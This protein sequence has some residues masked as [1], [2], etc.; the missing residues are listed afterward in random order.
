MFSAPAPGQLVGYYFV[1]VDTRWDDP[2][3]S[4]TDDFPSIITVVSTGILGDNVTN[5][6]AA[7]RIK[8]EIE[9]DSNFPPTAPMRVTDWVQEGGLPGTPPPAPF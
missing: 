9:I 7:Y 6:E 4:P 5:P 2:Q 1:T 3:E 8:M